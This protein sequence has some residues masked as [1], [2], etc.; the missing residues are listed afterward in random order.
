MVRKEIKYTD[1]EGN[2]ATWIAYFNLNRTECIDIDMEFEDEGGLMGHL[3]GLLPLLK[4]QENAKKKPLVDF[5]KLIVEKSYGVRPKSN[6]SLFLKEDED[7]RRVFYK[8]KASPAY[9]EFVFR[10]M[11]GEE[12]LS[13]FIE[14]VLP[15]VPEDDK[16]KAIMRMK[17]EGFD[18]G[19]EVN[20]SANNAAKL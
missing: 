14:N 9:D 10:L 2:E 15:E 5:V 17:E 18:L 4:Q 16:Q 11:T 20:A 3:K 8:F 7:G 1:F 12:P 13:E 6:P 19:E